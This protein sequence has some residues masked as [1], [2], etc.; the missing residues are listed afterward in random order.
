MYVTTAVIFFFFY[1]ETSWPIQVAHAFRKRE[2][3]GSTSAL[4][5]VVRLGSYLR[6]GTQKTA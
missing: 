1:L 5:K 6:N 3:C 4:K 2:R